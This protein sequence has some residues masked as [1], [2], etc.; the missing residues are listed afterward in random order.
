[1]PTLYN[2][3]SQSRID[4]V[5]LFTGSPNAKV[6]GAKPQAASG[7]PN[8]HG[9]NIREAVYCLEKVGLNVRFKGIGRVTGQS[10]K[11]GSNFNRG[12]VINL[13]LAS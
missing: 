9:M 11:A 13:Y 2:T 12:A 4:N 3:T 10:L 8:V 5:K 1:M 7:V 6:F